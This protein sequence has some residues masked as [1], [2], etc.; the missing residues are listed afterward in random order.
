MILFF[1]NLGKLMPTSV[2]GLHIVLNY[3]QLT[4]GLLTF[5]MLVVSMILNGFCIYL[6]FNVIK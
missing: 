4:S 1:A 6:L 2:R 3:W 5:T